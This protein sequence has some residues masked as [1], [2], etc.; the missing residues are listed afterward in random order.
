LVGKANKS[1]PE[2]KDSERERER[3]SVP[4]EE[5]NNTICRPNS[6]L[7]RHSSLLLSFFFF[8]L[9]MEIPNND[10]YTQN[11]KLLV[12]VLLVSRTYQGF[13]NK[14]FKKLFISNFVTSKIWWFFPNN[15]AKSTRIYTRGKKSHY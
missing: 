6:S 10:F 5:H 8:P 11:D 7:T 14:K 1:E 3:E 2:S 9:M 13:F 15:L 12:I 4:K